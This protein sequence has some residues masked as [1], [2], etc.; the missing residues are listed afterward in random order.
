MNEHTY[1]QYVIPQKEPK[2][3]MEI[4]KAVETLRER[5]RVDRRS[6]VH[7]SANDMAQSYHAEQAEAAEAILE[8]IEKLYRD[9]DHAVLAGAKVNQRLHV[10]E[11]HLEECALAEYR[12]RERHQNFY[13]CCTEC[14][15]DHSV[16]WPCPTLR[17]LIEEPSK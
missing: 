9:I 2:G 14:S 7:P 3:T 15:Q 16:K 5:A 6:A 12:V 4:E 17:D 11:K 8:H 13:G 10:A 1:C